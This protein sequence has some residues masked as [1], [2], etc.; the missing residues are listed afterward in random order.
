MNAR[1]SLCIVL[2]LSAAVAR[3]V[4]A[5]DFN[6]K[7]DVVYG[8]K[9][10]MALTF[11]VFEPKSDAK[12]VGLLFMVSGGWVSA[13]TPP[14]QGAVLFAPFLKAGYTVFAVR[15][16]SSPRYVIPEIAVDV[17]SALKYVYEHAEELK[18]DRDRL[19]VFGFSAGGHLSLMLGR[20][21]SPNV[22][23]GNKS[24]ARMWPR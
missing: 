16:G 8:H 24:Q 23:T 22:P 11:D 1:Y 13:W 2:L 15:H 21:Q 5:Q 14:N 17:R 7:P 6:F 20:D 10:G 12:G 18:V 4:Q 19:G 9:D 3:P